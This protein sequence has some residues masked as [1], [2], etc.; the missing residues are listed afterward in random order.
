[1]FEFIGDCI[2]TALKAGLGVVFIVL[3]WAGFQMAWNWTLDRIR[4]GFK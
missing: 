1:M 2:A 4:W 3:I